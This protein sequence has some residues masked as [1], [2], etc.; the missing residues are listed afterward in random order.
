MELL[1]ETRR[2]DE[3]QAA[4]SHYRTSIVVAA[5]I[6]QSFGRQLG[7]LAERN[8]PTDLAL[9]EIDRVQCAPGRRNRGVAVGTEEDHLSIGAVLEPVGVLRRALGI[10]R[11]IL[12]AHQELHDVIDG[13]IPERREARHA[14]AALPYDCRNLQAR[15]AFANVH[16]RWEGRRGTLQIVAMATGAIAQIGRAS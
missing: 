9:I 10:A 16:Q 13:R 4:G 2:A 5:G 15:E 6:L 1:V 12:A 11:A 3:K 14:A 7:N 8:L